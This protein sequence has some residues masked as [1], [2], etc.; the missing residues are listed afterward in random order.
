MR[1]EPVEAAHDGEQVLRAGGRDGDAAVEVLVV[2]DHARRVVQ[3]VD[4]VVDGG[5]LHTA[6]EEDGG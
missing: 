1:E 3:V 5:A 6:Q 2:V 4:H